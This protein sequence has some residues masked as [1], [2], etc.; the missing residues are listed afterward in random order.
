[1]TRIVKPGDANNLI[2]RY[3]NGEGAGA[4]GKAIGIAQSQALR[5]LHA[6][7][8]PIR[9]RRLRVPDSAI[10]RYINGESEVSLAIAFN[11]SRGVI[12]R[13]LIEANI[14]PRNHSEGMYVRMKR[15]PPDE[16][17]RLA[18]AAHTAIRGKMRS[19][20]ERARR[21]ITSQSTLR[22]VT[23]TETIV[24]DWLKVRDVTCTPQLAI[25]GYN[26][27]IAIH[28]PSV[29]LEIQC[30]GGGSASR[31]HNHIKR[32]KYLL[33]SGWHVLYVLISTSHPLLEALADNLVAW[34]ETLGRNKPYIGE[35]QVVRGDGEF[36]S[37]L[38]ADFQDGTCIMYRT[39]R[40]NTAGQHPV[41]RQ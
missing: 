11:V 26:V 40:N 3:L 39:R 27:D 8:I 38:S 6:Y 1:M 28:M 31:P 19:D 33:H 4:A 20:K 22:Y 10:G 13:Q 2:Q 36:V 7:K 25:G 12:R 32:T 24:M 17:L 37:S 15:T 23:P 29:A 16:R 5:I 14:S 30:S 35:Y 41:I 34:M 18:T 21:A 9:S